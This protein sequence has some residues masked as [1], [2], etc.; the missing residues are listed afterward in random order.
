LHQKGFVHSVEV[1]QDNELVGGL[2]GLILG[3]CFFGESM[4]AKVSN[5]S[6]VGFITLA[7]NLEAQNFA[8]IDCQVHTPHLESLG[9]EMIGRNSFL[10]IIKEHG[11]MKPFDLNSV[12]KY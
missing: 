4:F 9:A 5:A 8:L 12:F 10:K 11:A 6:K 2:Y 1:W 3:K 7:Q